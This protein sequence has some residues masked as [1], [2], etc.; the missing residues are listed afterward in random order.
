[1]IGGHYMKKTVCY[2]AQSEQTCSFVAQQL[3]H[4]LG[5]YIEVK[6]WALQHE[7]TMPYLDCDLYIVA[8]RMIL[9]TVADQLI[10]DKPVLLAVR[11]VNVENLDKLLEL[12]PG[13]RALVVAFYEGV[14]ND[15]INSLR[16]FGI[17]H[18][19]LIPYYPN[20]NMKV[21]KDINVAI[22]PGLAN[23]VPSNIKKV[24]DVGVRGINIS[25]FT[26]IIGY[27]NLPKEIINE[28]SD[29]YIK[30]IFNLSFKQYQMAS[31]NKEL[32]TKMEVI[33]NT[34]DEAIVAVDEDNRIIVFNPVCERILEI[35]SIQTIGR[36]VREVIPQVDFL[37][38]LKTGQGII[39]EI[40]RINDNYYIVSTNPVND[41]LG[42]THGVVAT[43]RPVMQVKEMEVKA[44]RE[45][46]GKGNI[47]KYTF[48][49]IVGESKELTR[50]LKLAKKFARTNLTVLIEGESGTGKEV[51]AQAI[52]NYSEVSDG[53]FVAINF[54]SLPENLVES[55]LF[56]YEDGA[57]TGAKKGGKAGLFEEAHSGTIFLDE[58]G[59]ASMEVQKRLLRVLEERKVRRVG[60][61]TLTPVDVRVIAATN[62]DLE[63]LVSQGKF[64]NDLYYRLCTLP[65]TIP[66]LHA[67]GQDIFTLLEYFTIKLYDRRL[68]LEDPLREFLMNYRW[69][70]NIRELRNVTEYLCNMVGEKEAATI[71]HLPS[72][73]TRNR[74]LKKIT[75]Y[76]PE[77][78]K[79]EKFDL[80]MLKLEKQGFL[81][82]V[83]IILEEIYNST[84][85]NK[86]IGRQALQKILQSRDKDFTDSKMRQWL[87]MLVEVGYVDSGKTK[88]G[89]KITEEGEQF[90]SHIKKRSEK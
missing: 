67:R 80:F 37:S 66:P 5:E 88:Q 22:T 65:I 23:L 59:D 73:M 9:E 85:L 84:I 75:F 61:N 53:P 71:K 41:E 28:I 1:M 76:E 52:H 34:V 83:I 13:T 14:V 57:F 45:I 90:L 70:G 58:I 62:Q 40:K 26:E 74:E 8:S 24:V 11:A 39:K 78:S 89:S 79:N 43:F 17:N 32:K 55:E 60:G 6:V 18:L 33:M 47:A 87:K 69:P 68:I 36:D 31:L 82:Q 48:S 44:R 21:P 27:L 20:N 77:R 46:V 63:K 72:Y 10:T 12:T 49:H 81:Q 16:K 4:F 42:I 25:T 38:C 35:N 50:A 86:G 30:N 7:N 56:G 2:I 54:A 29:F 15:T 3:T 51:F 64:R 19:D